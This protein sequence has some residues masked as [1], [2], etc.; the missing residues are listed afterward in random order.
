[1]KIPRRTFLKQSALGAGALLL[2][3]EFA[4]A[5]KT[6]YFDPYES[7]T[8]GKTGLNVSRLCLGTGM[9]GGKRESNQTRLGKEKFGQLI[10]GAYDRGIR[11]YDLADLYGTH[12][13]VVPAL[14]GIA[15]DKYILISKV[16]FRPGGIPEPERP[17]ADV[18]VQRFLKEIGTDYIDLVLLHCCTAGTWTTDLKKQMELLA[19][20]KQKGTIR[21]HGVSCHSMEALQT[22]ANDP[23]VD[24]VHTRI[25]PYGMS[26]DGPPEKVVPMI[27]HLH[28]AG[29]GVVGMKIVGEGKLRNDPVKRQESIKFA[30]QS[31]IVDVLNVGFESTAEIDDFAAMV[32]KVPRQSVA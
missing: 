7:V 32:K 25:N 20:L 4:A 18:V 21:A 27:K 28:D 15:R 29:K 13:Y 9:K 14:K 1:M 17:D 26:M 19:K 30:L 23:W 3:T 6:A 31:G 8:L 10:R 5:K 24:S 12:P 2:G 11:V 22:A 16:W